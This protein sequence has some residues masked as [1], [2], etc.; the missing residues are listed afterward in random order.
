[1]RG[2]RVI[3]SDQFFEPGRQS[4]CEC[5]GNV[6][7]VHIGGNT[8]DHRVTDGAITE[9]IFEVQIVDLSGRHQRYGASKR[10]TRRNLGFVERAWI[11]VGSCPSQAFRQIEVQIGNVVDDDH[12]LSG[13]AKTLQ[14][15]GDPA[16]IIFAPPTRFIEKFLIVGVIC[17]DDRIDLFVGDDRR[18]GHPPPFSA[19][20]RYSGSR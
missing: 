2:S 1:M 6:T 19:A 13:H 14:D 20:S 9:H 18:Y 11:V 3:L 12:S 15:R 4:T 7:V 10:R 5:G 8:S 16:T 17:D